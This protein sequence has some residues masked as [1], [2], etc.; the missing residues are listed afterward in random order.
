MT[1]RGERGKRKQPSLMEVKV[2]YFYTFYKSKRL[3]PHITRALAG[4]L[5]GPKQ[6]R[7]FDI[8]LQHFAMDLP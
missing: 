7:G 8:M 5:K 4:F 6:M 1:R 3:Y 2:F